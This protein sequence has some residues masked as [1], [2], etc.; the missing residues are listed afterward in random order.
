MSGSRLE[1]QI[2]LFRESELGSIA[3]ALVG[4]LIG[5]V[6]KCAPAQRARFSAN[7]AACT[8]GDH[9]KAS[10]IQG[11]FE[12]PTRK[13]QRLSPGNLS[14]PAALPTPKVPAVGRGLGKSNY[15]ATREQSMA[16]LH[17]DA[18][19]ADLCDPS[20]SH[21]TIRLTEWTDHRVQRCPLSR[22]KRKTS[23]RSEYF[24]F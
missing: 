16:S 15:V 3:S 9:G 21:P 23:A 20:L 4:F 2:R 19:R 8:R 7:A 24:A 5:N 22:A 10:L 18:G 12:Q 1:N 11:R 6:W 14:E 13:L 17:P